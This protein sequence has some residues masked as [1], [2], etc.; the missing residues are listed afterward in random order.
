MKWSLKSTRRPKRLFKIFFTSLT[1]RASPS[2]DWRIA[3]KTRSREKTQRIWF[4]MLYKRP[5]HRSRKIRHNLVFERSSD[6]RWAPLMNFRDSRE[7]TSSCKLDYKRRYCPYEITSSTG[8]WTAK[9]TAQ[10]NHGIA[11]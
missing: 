8:T 3:V 1:R 11:I 9:I 10:V 5:N 6:S 4:W 7:K 2:T